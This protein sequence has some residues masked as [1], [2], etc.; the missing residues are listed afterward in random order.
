MRRRTAADGSLV[1]SPWSFVDWGHAAPASGPDV[2]VTAILLAAARD[3]RRWETLLGEDDAAGASAYA[4]RLSA[5]LTA[6]LPEDDDVEAWRRLGHHAT[7]WS[8]RC[9]VVPVE[10]R[11]A[12]LQAV[13]DHL[14]Q[15]F[16]N[17]PTA[18]R[19]RDPGVRDP[20][21]VTPFFGHFALGVLLEAGDVDFVVEQW[22]SCWG[23][24]LDQ[25][26]RTWWEVFDEGWSHGHFWSGCP[27]WQ[28]TRYLL[29]LRT[30]WDRG[31]GEVDLLLAPGSLPRAAGTV[32]LPDGHVEVEWERIGDR[33]AWSARPSRSLVV[34][35]AGE[36]HAVAA[37]AT[38]AI[39][40]ESV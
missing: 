39:A 6:R 31:P 21:I 9:D 4:E 29:G 36:R 40:L 5:A 18:P 33:I 1:G 13:R 14:R 26:A 19:L 3:L 38:L 27:T 35:H 8:L 2:A 37:G 10:R 22:R 28:M 11:E 23:W 30:R 24:M 12:A 17:D 25:G 34:E 7:V 16:P 20:R 32:A 15:G